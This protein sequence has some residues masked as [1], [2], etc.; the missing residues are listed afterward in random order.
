MALKLSQDILNGIIGGPTTAAPGPNETALLARLDG[1][2]RHGLKSAGVFWAPGAVQRN[3][4]EELCGH[5]LS[6]D[7]AT[8]RI[9]DISESRP[10]RTHRI[11]TDVRDLVGG[12]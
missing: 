11:P 10:P 3:T 7:F 8:A 4:R 6:I 12:L 1:A 9:H 2:V 5:L